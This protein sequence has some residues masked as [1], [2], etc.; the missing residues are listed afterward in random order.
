MEEQDLDKI[1]EEKEQ[2]ITRNS[3][4]LEEQEIVWGSQKLREREQVD[5]EIRKNVSRITGVTRNRKREQYEDK[6]QGTKRSKKAKY[7]KEPDNWGD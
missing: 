5:R 4:A 3:E 6:E 7:I 2:E 1:R